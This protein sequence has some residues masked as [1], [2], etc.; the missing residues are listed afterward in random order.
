MERKF[1]NNEAGRKF[2]TGLLLIT[3]ALLAL[4]VPVVIDK[5]TDFNSFRMG[6]LNQPFSDEMGNVLIYLLPSLEILTIILL[7]SKKNNRYGIYLSAILMFLF[8]GYV[9]LALAGAWEKLPCGCGSI[10]SGMTWNEHFF[11]NLAFLALSIAGIYLSHSQRRNPT[12]CE[13]AE[14]GSAKRQYKTHFFTFKF[15]KK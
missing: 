2:G 10:I 11:F 7:I 9:G 14:G 3:I 1:N 6:I 12:G 13:V 8:T 4:W 15:S 5:L